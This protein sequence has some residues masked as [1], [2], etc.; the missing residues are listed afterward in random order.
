MTPF[1]PSSQPARRGRE[2]SIRHHH[3]ALMM[4]GGIFA[5][6]QPQAVPTCWASR[7]IS[8][9][10]L[11]PAAPLTYRLRH[12]SLATLLCHVD[13]TGY[14]PLAGALPTDHPLPRGIYL[15]DSPMLGHPFVPTILCH[16]DL[17]G[18]SSVRVIRAPFSAAF[19][20]PKL[21]T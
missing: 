19:C 7:H 20:Y 6:H 14:P 11:P 10:L 2:S 1:I 9:G 4:R 3:C 21:L 18:R 16:V 8:P 15:V 12:F 17:I 5:S 13:F